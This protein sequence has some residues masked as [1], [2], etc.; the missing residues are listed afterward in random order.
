MVSK[1]YEI[2][3]NIQIYM[4]QQNNKIVFCYVKFSDQLL[5]KIDF[6]KVD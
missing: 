2:L 6:Q 4:Y 3:R 1:W 5:F